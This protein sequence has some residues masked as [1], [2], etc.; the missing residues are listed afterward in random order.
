MLKSSMYKYGKMVYVQCEWW[1]DNVKK[2]KCKL[3]G[4][5]LRYKPDSAVSLVHPTANKD[6]MDKNGIK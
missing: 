2:G 5:D 6:V 1:V 3:P 4:L